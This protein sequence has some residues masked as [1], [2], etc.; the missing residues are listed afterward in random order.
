MPN[1][2]ESDLLVF[3]PQAQLD[4]FMKFAK[5]D[6]SEFDFDKFV[7]YP[8]FFRRLDEAAKA[9]EMAPFK[10]GDCPR[11]GFNSGGY[12]WCVEQWGTKWPAHRVRIEEVDTYE[13]EG[14]V[15][16]HFSTAWTPPLPIIRTAARLYP[17]LMFELRY[18]ECGME[19]DGILV[20]QN[21]NVLRDE[22]SP[23]FGN[24]GG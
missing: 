18:F 16:I 2:C 22:T 8:E 11:D 1:W 21:G 6:S 5:S 10:D 9:W 3:G 17:D 14:S 20:C 13:D 15:V 19:F 4:D 23:Y 24:R 7:A 12:E